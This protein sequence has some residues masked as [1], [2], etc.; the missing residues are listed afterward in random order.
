MNHQI[1]LLEETYVFHQN[2]NTWVTPQLGIWTI[3]IA[4]HCHHRTAILLDAGRDAMHQEGS[5][6]I[7]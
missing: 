4:T 7:T 3:T 6:T 5:T 1:V 2:T